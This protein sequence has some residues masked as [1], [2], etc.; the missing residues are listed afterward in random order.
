M[1]VVAIQGTTV[2]RADRSGP[3]GKGYDESGVQFTLTKTDIHAIAFEPGV[4]GRL[5]GHHYSDV[6][7]TLRKDAGDNQMAVAFS[8]KDN[9]ADASMD[10]SPTMRSMGH[11]ESHA[12]GGGQLAVAFKS[13]AALW[14]SQRGLCALTGVRLGRTA[15]LDHII[16]KARG[17]S[18]HIGNLR[19]VSFSANMLK[20]DLLDEELFEIAVQVVSVLSSRLDQH[21]KAQQ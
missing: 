13:L 5:G 21:L 14:R 17:G 2:G 18:D 8:S 6:S 20:R 12:N 3:Q 9:G 19:W 1:D 4:T 11:N 10:L 15:N 16:P 7:G